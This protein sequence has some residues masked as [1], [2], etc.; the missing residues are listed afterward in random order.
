MDNDIKILTQIKH[1]L[2]ENDTVSKV[3]MFYNLE[4]DW[5]ISYWQD[6][7]KKLLTIDI[8]ESEEENE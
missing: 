7:F 4:G 1:M 3:E 2:R 8:I 5:V 6:G